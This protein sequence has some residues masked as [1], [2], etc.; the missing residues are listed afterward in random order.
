MTLRDECKWI[1]EEVT[2]SHKLSG[3]IALCKGCRKKSIADTCLLAM[4]PP[5]YRRHDLKLGY[6]TEHGIS[7]LGQRLK[8]AWNGSR[9][10]PYEWRYSV[11]TERS[12]GLRLFSALFTT[13]T[14]RE[15]EPSGGWLTNEYTRTQNSA[16]WVQPCCK[17]I[18]QEISGK[19]QFDKTS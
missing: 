17:R 1:A 18:P 2:K 19:S 13:T 6:I 9:A 10:K 12:E 8:K 14:L 11:K 5:L 7:V 4:R 16:D 15:G 3:K